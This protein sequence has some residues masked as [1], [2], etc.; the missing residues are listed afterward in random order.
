MSH[1]CPGLCGRTVPQGVTFAC[2]DCTADLPPALRL[3][4]GATYSNGQWDEHCRAL[5]DAL[6]WF[7]A[8]RRA[9]KENKP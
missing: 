9:R 5:S 7:T 3:H 2:R 4:I 6:L 8:D 1:T